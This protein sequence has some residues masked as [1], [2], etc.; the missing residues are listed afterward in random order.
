M[1]MS[2]NPLSTKTVLSQS[3]LRAVLLP[4]LRTQA[5]IESVIGIGMITAYTLAILG[6]LTVILRLFPLSWILDA[7]VAAILG[8]GIG[9]RSRICASLAFILFVTGQI[10]AFATGVHWNPLLGTT[11]VP[12]SHPLLSLLVAFFFMNAVGGTF[13]FHSI[14]KSQDHD[15]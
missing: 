14:K 8:F 7:V 10:I 13:A 1:G 5:D 4:N 11:P 9:R 2:Q 3:R 12:G 6:C 15:R